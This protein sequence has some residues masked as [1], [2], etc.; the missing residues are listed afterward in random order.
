VTDVVES[1]QMTGDDFKPR[2]A[3]KQKHS[4]NAKTAR[5]RAAETLKTGLEAAE[6]KARSAYRVNKSLGLA[7]L[8]NSA[9]WKILSETEQTKRQNEVV[10]A[11]EQKLCNRMEALHREWRR[12]LVDNDFDSE[13]E[14]IEEEDSDDNALQD[15]IVKNSDDWEDEDLAEIN[16]TLSNVVKESAVEWNIKMGKWEHLALQESLEESL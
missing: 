4:D 15:E 13:E 5:N 1:E 2:K 8:Q 6:L 7:K 14:P 9:G 3:R 11:A 12:K 10:D 16:Q